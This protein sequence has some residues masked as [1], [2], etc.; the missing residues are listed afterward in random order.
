MNGYPTHRAQ[1]GQDVRRATTQRPLKL[2]MLLPAYSPQL[3][4]DEWVWHDRVRRTSANPC[5]EFTANV[6]AALKGISRIVRGFFADP[7]LGLHRR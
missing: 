7:D 3:N 5:E 4:P 1:E 6:Y 2:F